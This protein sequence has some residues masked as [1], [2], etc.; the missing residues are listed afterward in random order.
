[1]YNCMYSIWT[2]SSWY[3]SSDVPCHN[4]YN[5]TSQG[6]SY[7]DHICDRLYCSLRSNH[8]S[9]DRP[10]NLPNRQHHSADCARCQRWF[11]LHDH[12]DQR[13]RLLVDAHRALIS[14]SVWHY[15]IPSIPYSDTSCTFFLQPA[16]SNWLY[17]CLYVESAYLSSHTSVV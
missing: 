10:V 13:S 9:D 15:T 4:K 8:F 12:I 14:S 17:S 6:H 16:K 5:H 2:P 11:L 3:F 7:S 1:M